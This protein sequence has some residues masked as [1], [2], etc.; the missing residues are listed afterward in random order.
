MLIRA[1]PQLQNAL[2]VIHS[3]TKIL[4]IHIFIVEGERS[5]DVKATDKRLVGTNTSSERAML[6]KEVGKLV[7]TK[8]P[9][10]LAPKSKK[11]KYVECC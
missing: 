10:K 11:K 7:I 3:A 6:T 1:V 4:G 8:C 9:E 5:V 2:F